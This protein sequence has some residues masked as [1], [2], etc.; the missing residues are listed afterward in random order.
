MSINLS[1]TLEQQPTNAEIITQQPYQVFLLDPMDLTEAHQEFLDE[2]KPTLAE[3]CRLVGNARTEIIKEMQNDGI[4]I[5]TK[6]EVELI[7]SEYD[8]KSADSQITIDKDHLDSL[9]MMLNGNTQGRSLN[10]PVNI[11]R[12]LSREHR[13]NLMRIDANPELDEEF[14][15]LKQLNDDISKAETVIRRRKQVLATSL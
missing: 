9:F 10:S 12:R 3:I 4:P 5:P 14:L 11:I 2:G 6:A 13:N 15:I 8:V 7:F 1:T